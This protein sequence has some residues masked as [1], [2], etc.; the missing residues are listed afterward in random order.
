MENFDTILSN[1]R[2][3]RLGEPEAPP[4]NFRVPLPD[5]EEPIDETQNQEAYRSHLKTLPE[6]DAYQPGPVKGIL[7]TLAGALAGFG[8]DSAV[9]GA[10][11]G[12]NVIDAPYRNAINQYN[13]KAK[14]LGA[15]SD[16]ELGRNKER[17]LLFFNRKNLDARVQAENDRNEDRDLA[18]Q[19]RKKALETR[20]PKQYKPEIEY[21]EKGYA[22]GRI[23]DPD[24]LELKEVPSLKG[25]RRGAESPAITQKKSNYDMA[26]K[27]A[28]DLE[29]LFNKVSAKYQVPFLGNPHVGP[30][31]GTI[32]EWL[33]DAGAID[34]EDVINMHE[35][36][37]E[38]ANYE[39]YSLSGA[40]INNKEYDRLR[41]T[42][43]DPGKSEA[44][45]RA[46]LK[47]FI[48]YHKAAQQGLISEND[49]DWI[50]PEDDVPTG[51]TNTPAV[52]QSGN[53]TGS[54]YKV[55]RLS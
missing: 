3:R 38:M 28:G 50:P 42:L 54:K 51:N 31:Q 11:L 53:P 19:E 6:Q 48:K 17:R 44:K 52:P 20:P 47:R 1:L 8:Q 46:D 40:Q 39:L 45:F 7:A 22:T 18:R 10:A 43:A 27:R 36:A 29:S 15:L 37:R 33:G 9:A 49:R 26:I 14:T 5:L 4:A 30:I 25:F 16:D 32:S 35:T 12:R 24:S 41:R 13:T 55:R 23:F 34:D 2:L 21:D